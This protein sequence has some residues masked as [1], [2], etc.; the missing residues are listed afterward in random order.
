MTGTKIGRNKTM[1]C[2]SRHPSI[3]PESNLNS[4]NSRYFNMQDIINVSILFK[5]KIKKFPVFHLS[6]II[7]LI[8]TNKLIFEPVMRSDP[9]SYT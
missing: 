3:V 8:I 7:Y 2:H 4:C 9:S 6:T 1:K 5:M